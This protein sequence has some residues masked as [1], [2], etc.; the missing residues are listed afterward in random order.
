MKLKLPCLKVLLVLCC[1]LPLHCFSQ[2]TLSTAQK[3]L[4]FPDKVFS[5]IAEKEQKLSSLL[6]KKTEKYL[7]KLQRQESKLKRTLLQKDSL[8]AKELFPDVKQPY[9]YIKQK[10]GELGALSSVYSGRLDSLTTAL[11]F[12]QKPQLANLSKPAEVEKTLKGLQDL[13]GKLNATEAIKK[14]LQERRALL[15]EHFERLGM[16]RELKAYKKQVF[17][18]QTQLEEYRQLINDPSKWEAKLLE[19]VQKLPQ[20]QA[21]FARNSQLA[22]LFQLPGAG[23]SA[24]AGG[25]AASLAGLQTRASVQQAIQERFGSGAEVSSMLQERVQGAQ[26]QLSELKDKAQ[27]YT[28]GSFGSSTEELSMPEGFKPNNQKSKSFLKR[29]ELGTNFQSQRA[30]NYFP[31]TSDVGLS[32]GYK[33]NDKSVVGVGASYKVGWG[34]GWDHIAISHQGVGLRSYVDWKLKGSIYL[35]GGYEQNYRSA[36]NS[37]QALKDYSAWQGSGLLGLTKKYKAGK[38]KGTMQ[39]LWDFL[40]Y[41]QV[42]RTQTILWRV[43]YNLK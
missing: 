6:D 27:K 28:T 26:S 17:Y 4:A 22:Q 11:Q 25:A 13:Q 2:D 38:L 20:F 10:A 24:G 18:Y 42:P 41:Q 33:I 29:L 19:V 37:T 34:R 21:F 40:S 3:L 9:A 1:A 7:A 36:F 12:L 14:Q 15:Q 39:L 30:R 23:G 8:L 16:V 5:A 43:G 35:S 32:L 31:V